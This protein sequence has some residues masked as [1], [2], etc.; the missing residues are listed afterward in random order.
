MLSS[1]PAGIRTFRE[2]GGQVQHISRAARALV[3]SGCSGA[4]DEG[5]RDSAAISLVLDLQHRGLS[6]DGGRK[7]SSLKVDFKRSMNK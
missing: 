1:P 3:S 5:K 6:W 2:K 7:V 4:W